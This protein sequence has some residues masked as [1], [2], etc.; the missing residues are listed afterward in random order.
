MRWPGW[1]R[2]LTVRPV[3][4]AGRGRRA[5]HYGQ[6]LSGSLPALATV[7]AESELGAGSLN[8][9]SGR[10][11]GLVKVTACLQACA[12]LC[13]RGRDAACLRVVEGCQH[14]S[15]AVVAGGVASDSCLRRSA[16]AVRDASASGPASAVVSAVIQSSPLG[17][18]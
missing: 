11:R 16:V 1:C 3:R 18:Q 4:L 12:D 5:V 15:G 2:R 14:A 13:D 8:C 6:L 10:V 9:G 17:C 7:W